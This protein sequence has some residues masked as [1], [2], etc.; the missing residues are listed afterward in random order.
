M[1]I[2]VFHDLPCPWC[3]I[4]KRHLDAALAAWDGPAPTVHWHPFFLDPT[5][6]S[7]GRDFRTHMA[8]TKGGTDTLEPMFEVVR[9]AGAASD[10]TFRFDRV[11]R[12]PNSL[13]AHRLLAL[14]PETH[15]APL[16]D[17]IHRA[18]FED[19]RDIGDVAQLAEVAG[20]VGLDPDDV[21]AL[22]AGDAARDEVL[23]EAAWARRQGVGGVPL[24]AIDGVVAFSGAQPPEA[25]LAA[26]R[27]AAAA[28]PV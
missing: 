10:L 4:G 17:A 12:A 3:R 7:E 8:A 26:M 24:F 19:G 23:A 14:T 25:L 22:L 28:T 5:I 18:Y 13:A 20:S 2:D 9:R 21:R 27:E 16:L 1:R 11:T 15:Q 6:P